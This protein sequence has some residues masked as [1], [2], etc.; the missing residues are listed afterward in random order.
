LPTPHTSATFVVDE[1]GISIQRRRIGPSATLAQ[2]ELRRLVVE[3]D[4]GK[5]TAAIEAA[6]AARFA[7]VSAL[8]L[9]LGRIGVEEVDVVTSTPIRSIESARA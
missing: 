9:A 2:G 3:V 1:L 5:G 7:D 4:A 6:R 8:V